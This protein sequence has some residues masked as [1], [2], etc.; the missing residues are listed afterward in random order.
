MVAG[1][2]PSS[3]VTKTTNPKR[4]PGCAPCART[5]A[6]A[7]QAS[8]SDADRRL[9]W[10]DGC[11]IG[12]GIRGFVDRALRATVGGGEVAVVEGGVRRLARGRAVSSGAL[13]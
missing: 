12:R 8:K 9:A 13:A 2:S 7:A 1:A 5:V 3:A 10:P 11:A 4:R 6:A